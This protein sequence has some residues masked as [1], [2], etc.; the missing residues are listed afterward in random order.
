MFCYAR[1][2]GC[3]DTFAKWTKCEFYWA[4]WE[5]L[6]NEKC[7]WSMRDYT[8]SNFYHKSFAECFT[9]KK[10]TTFPSSCGVWLQQRKSKSRKYTTARCWYTTSIKP[11][12]PTMFI[13]SGLLLSDLT[14]FV[15]P[16]WTHHYMSFRTSAFNDLGPMLKGNVS[17]SY[18]CSR[19][20]ALVLSAVVIRHMMMKCCLLFSVKHSAKK[21]EI[22]K[23][24]TANAISR[25][26]RA[27]CVFLGTSHIARGILLYTWIIITEFECNMLVNPIIVVLTAKFPRAMFIWQWIFVTEIVAKYLRSHRAKKFVK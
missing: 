16:N 9:E 1:F 4:M 13:N 19:P 27:F 21:F 20:T 6:K 23:R 12:F 25:A 26:P 11:F 3:R 10:N 17:D 24:N 8:C 7:T 22:K 5:V 2:W 18:C 15:K 14:V